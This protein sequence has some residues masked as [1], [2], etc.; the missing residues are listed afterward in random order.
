MDKAVIKRRRID[1]SAAVCTIPLL[2]MWFRDQNLQ[3]EEAPKKPSEIKLVLPDPL[4][5]RLVD[6]SVQMRKQRLV[7]LPRAVTISSILDQY[8]QARFVSCC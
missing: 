7:F 2:D 6:D 5:R 3:E 8:L 1:N 4:K